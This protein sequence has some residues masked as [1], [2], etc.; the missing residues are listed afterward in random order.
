MLHTWG[1]VLWIGEVKMKGKKE[2][3]GDEEED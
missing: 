3:G 2:E 1:V